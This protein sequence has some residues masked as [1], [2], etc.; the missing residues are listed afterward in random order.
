MRFATGQES[1]PEVQAVPPFDGSYDLMFVIDL[2]SVQ[3][4]EFC[5]TADGNVLCYCT[6]PITNEE[7]QTRSL[8]AEKDLKQ[9]VR[10][11]KAKSESPLEDEGGKRYREDF[12]DPE[13]GA[14]MYDDGCGDRWLGQ[15]SKNIHNMCLDKGTARPT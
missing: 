15:R 8:S 7:K 4:C 14:K 5:Q 3:S 9:L 10:K 11:A 2:E 6:V 1:Q 13:R 12:Y